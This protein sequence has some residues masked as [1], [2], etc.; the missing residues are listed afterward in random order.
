MGSASVFIKDSGY[1]HQQLNIIIDK[2]CSGF[3]FMLL[4]YLMLTFLTL[5]HSKSVLKKTLTLFISLFAAYVITVFVNSSRI[6][7]S[8]IIQSQN[9]YFSNHPLA[10]ESIGIITNL[11]FL[12]LIYLTLEKLLLKRQINEKLT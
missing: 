4:T 6:F 7:T 2:S 9:N 3:N 8:I 11:T 10:H 5:K 12:V 1:F